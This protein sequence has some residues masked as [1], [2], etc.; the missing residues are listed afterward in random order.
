MAFAGVAALAAGEVTT[1]T[2]LAAVTEVGTT[3]AVVGA[4][5][6]SKDLAQIGAVMG[7][8]GGVGGAI[9]GGATSALAG[10]DAVNSFDSGA[11]QGLVDGASGAVGTGAAIG[12]SNALSDAN[13]AGADWTGSAAETAPVTAQTAVQPQTLGPAGMPAGTTMTSVMQ[14]TTGTP[15]LAGTT[16]ATGQ[17]PATFQTGAQAP[18]GAEAPASPADDVPNPTDQR[19]ADGTQRP[20]GVPN[21]SS[22][23]L[24]ARFSDWASKNKT[25]FNAGQQIVGGALSG[26]NQR[27]MA[28]QKMQFQRD[29]WNRANS[30]GSFSPSLS[31]PA[32]GIVGRAAA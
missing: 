21:L 12:A 5:T 15:D 20:P 3:M 4:V 30:V 27:D 1:A 8:V 6:G 25:L 16:Q 23:S 2:V 26:M 11:M 9:A 22:D 31:V 32:T 17:Q 18:V 29:M 24:F 28:D 7:L 19:L 14:P 13:Y 10:A